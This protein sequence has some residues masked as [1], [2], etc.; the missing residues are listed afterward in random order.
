MKN[1]QDRTVTTSLIALLLVAMLGL[2]VAA[3]AQV[4][5]RIY[6]KV[7]D[8][9]G[10]PIE[11]A[12]V[13]IETWTADTK[14]RL[15]VESDKKGRYRAVF[16]HP[17]RDYMFQIRKDGFLPHDELLELGLQRNDLNTPIQRNF[18]LRSGRG[19][20]DSSNSPAVP[21][22]NKGVK[23][24]GD[25]DLETARLRLQEAVGADP[26]FALAYV[27]L[28]QVYRDLGDRELAAG[29][30]ERAIELDPE[31][32]RALTVH[33]EICSALGLTED[34]NR[35]LDA[36]AVQDPSEATAKRLFNAGTDALAAED[37]SQAEKRFRQSLDIDPALAT[38]REGLARAYLSQ[39]KFRAAV[40][41]TERLLEEEPDNYNGLLVRL[42]A[43]EGL[44]D[45]EKAAQAKEDLELAM[46]SM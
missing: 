16:L 14:H 36:L 27:A 12:E 15:R 5:Q 2:A 43:Y 9:D 8:E 45:Q 34:A 39:R 28:A 18:R 11:G 19:R 6:G 29:V 38:A 4:G 20:P 24:L 35:S 42:R 31:N 33:Y 7:L 25:D 32:A 40:E 21:L 13:I 44:G 1:V 26:D 17:A 23:A 22:Y 3:S 37:W 46:G 30:A 41:E 10:Q